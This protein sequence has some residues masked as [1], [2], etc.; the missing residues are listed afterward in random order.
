L[1]KLPFKARFSTIVIWAFADLRRDLIISFMSV[2][3]L[4][5]LIGP[6][7]FLEVLRTGVVENWAAALQTDPRNREVVIIGET[8]LS[9]ADLAALKA[10]PQTGFVVPEPSTFI[11][12]VRLQASGRPVAMHMRTS[13]PGD[14]ILG[15]APAPTTPDQ[16]TLTESAALL[17]GVA[18]GDILT[19]TLRRRPRNKEQENLS[20]SLQVLAVVPKEI[21]NEEVAFLHPARAAGATLWLQ[22]SSGRQD[23]L[24]GLGDD[25]W[26]SFRI[27]AD[28]VRQAPL[29][30]EQLNGLGYETRIASEQVSLLVKLSDGLRRLMAISVIGGMAGLSVAVWLLQVLS[31]ARHRREIALMTAAGLDRAGLITFFVF[32]GLILS[33]LA[34][35]LA[36]GCILPMRDVASTFSDRFLQSASGSGSF[37]PTLVFSAAIAVFCLALGAAASAAWRIRKFDLSADLRAD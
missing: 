2:I 30:A 23:A 29:L 13:A 24:A 33:A 17:L 9:N 16:V 18:T 1:Q 21:W 25:V 14:P 7:L 26:R 35:L 10:L 27:Y 12:T 36:I 8:S 37:D 28:K 11:S 19:M 31:V 34:L 5:L 20:I 22:P 6:P 3:L 15:P 4:F 32:Q